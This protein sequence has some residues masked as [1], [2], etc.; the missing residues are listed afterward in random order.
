VKKLRKV[1]KNFNPPEVTPVGL[2]PPSV[3]S[4][5]LSNR[6]M[7][8]LNYFFLMFSVTFY[9][10]SISENEILNKAKAIIRREILGSGL[11]LI[12][13]ILFGS[14]ATR[15]ARPD[16]DWDLLVVVSEQLDFNKKAEIATKIRR[17]FASL[18]VDAD[19]I[20]KSKSQLL[21][22]KDNTGLL[23]HYILQ[24]GLFL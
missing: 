16:S 18:G 19:I 15:Q 17:R 2:R 21:V 24:E 9:Y 10:D 8:R 20:I 1:R 11:T 14:R 7:N 3:T 5:G 22:E 23:A 13:V 6:I 4:G 12:D